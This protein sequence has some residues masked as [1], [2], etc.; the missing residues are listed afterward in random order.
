M[1]TVVD[2]MDLAVAERAQFVE[3]LDGLSAEQWDAPTLCTEWSVRQ[4][5]AHTFG[6]DP[7]GWWGAIGVLLRG[8]LDPDRANGLEIAPHAHDRPEQLLAMARDHLRPRGL[9]GGFGGRIA[10]T[11]GL[12]H[13]QDIRRP[14]GLPREIPADRL[15]VALE[16]GSTARPIRAK[17]R[18]RGLTLVATDVGWRS[19]E[20]PVVAGP[21][22]A[23]ILAMAGRHGI[24]DELSGPGLPILA[25]R[26]GD[27]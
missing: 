1:S 6:Y 21:G 15:R 12:I 20:G 2:P 18:V 9:T 22:E 17:Q 24:V 5:V 14:L 3:L 7:L 26:I 10:L 4:V 19:G 27:R 8:G 11:D 23:L 13:Q 16:F 25:D